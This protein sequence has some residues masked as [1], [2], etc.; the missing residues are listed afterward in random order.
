MGMPPPGLTEPPTK[1]RFGY[2]VLCL[3]ALKAR[4]FQR[5]LTTP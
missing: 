5:S 1:N 4:F 3:G 2:F